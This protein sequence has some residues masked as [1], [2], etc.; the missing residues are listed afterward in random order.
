MITWLPQIGFG[1][2]ARRLDDKRLEKQFEMCHD[3]MYAL[4]DGDD[5]PEEV[6]MWSGYEQRFCLY[7][8]MVGL[9]LHTQR[10]TGADTTCFHEWMR[11]LKDAGIGSARPPWEKDADIIRSHRSRLIA[12][13]RE[14]Y[15]P[16]FPR[17]PDKM[18]VL[19]PQV[20]KQDPGT[21]RLRLKTEDVRR[22]GTG[23]RKLPEWLYYNPEKNEVLARRSN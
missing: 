13:D 3:I 10:H 9:E 17:T 23:S 4:E 5:W 12:M 22:L 2:A 18:P 14:R 21:Y 20:L 6:R 16:M 19:W 7:S 8:M 15:A 11:E 1:A